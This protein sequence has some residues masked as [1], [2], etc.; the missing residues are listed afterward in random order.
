[1]LGDVVVPKDPDDAQTEIDWV[2]DLPDRLDD[3]LEWLRDAGFDAEALWTY[4][5]LAI[6]RAR[7]PRRSG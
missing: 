4:K 3:Q 5:D 1:M 2:V 6:V 7:R